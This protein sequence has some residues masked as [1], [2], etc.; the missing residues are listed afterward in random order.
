MSLRFDTVNKKPKLYFLIP[1][2]IAAAVIE[3]LLIKNGAQKNSVA[4]CSVTIA[5]LTVCAGS[6]AWAFVRQLKYNPYSY[7]TIYYFGFFLF[8]LS[9]IVTHALLLMQMLTSAEP[10]PVMMIPSTLMNAAKTYMLLSFPFLFAFSAA[11]IVSNIS[12]LI[13]ERKR[14]AN[15]LGIILALLI[16]GGEVFLFSVDYYVEGSQQEVMW[17]EILTN[18]FASVFLYLEC[19]LIGAIAANIIVVRYK[20]DTD[21]SYLIVLGCGL[22]RDGTPTPLLR[23]RIDRAIEFYNRQQA[24]TGKPPVIISSGGKGEDE[25]VSES[26]AMK[27]YMIEKGIPEEMIVMEEQSR[28]TVQNMRFSKQ[29]IAERSPNG[30]YDRGEKVAYATSNYHVFRSGLCARRVKMRAV[31]IGAKTK[32]YFWPNAA[33]REFVGLLTE[34]RVKQA[35]I[36]TCMIAVFA[37]LTVA[38]YSY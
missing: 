24:E 36:L 20:V 29:K 3:Y 18:L 22:R 25:V 14:F 38:V 23:G 5:F 15:V 2:A 27:R 6:L 19:M 13:H 37:A 7:N 17:H 26:L 33:V 11:L 4:L 12:L 34:H 9:I 1:A 30:E 35:V 28:D 10:V 16:I 31:G 32:W 21:R 8:V